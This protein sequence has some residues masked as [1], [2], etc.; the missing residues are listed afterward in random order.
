ML[1]FFYERIDDD[2]LV[3]LCY[4]AFD[5]GEEVREVWLGD[6]ACGDVFFE[7]QVFDEAIVDEV[8]IDEA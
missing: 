5:V 1:A 8:G 2:A 4:F 6:D 3:L 7:R